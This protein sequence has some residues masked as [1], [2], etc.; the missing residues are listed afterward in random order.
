MPDGR[1]SVDRADGG[2][3]TS[4]NWEDDERVVGFTLGRRDQAGFGA[5]RLEKANIDSVRQLGCKDDLGYERAKLEDN[6]H[7]GNLVF[8]KNCLKSRQKMIAAAL[9][10]AAQ[11][12][13]PPPT[14]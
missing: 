9:A 10:L 12:V 11:H 1:T 2:L 7:H 3:E 5:A 13:P 14:S 6:P 4:I 8:E